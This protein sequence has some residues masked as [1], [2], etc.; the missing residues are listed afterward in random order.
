M[1]N[2]LSPRAILQWWLKLPVALH[3]IWSRDPSRSTYSSAS[4]WGSL[5]SSNNTLWANSI[6][7]ATFGHLW[8]RSVF[9]FTFPLLQMLHYVL[10]N[11]ASVTTVPRFGVGDGTGRRK[12]IVGGRRLCTAW[13]HHAVRILQTAQ[14]TV[15]F[16]IAMILWWIER[17]RLRK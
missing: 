16:I 1:S 13:S 10:F 8:T 4:E 7:R 3:G 14:Y 5:H 9:T 2:R 15:L 17:K 11:E 12:C 6:I